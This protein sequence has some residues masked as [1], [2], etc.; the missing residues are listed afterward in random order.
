METNE[1]QKY[2]KTKKSKDDKLRKNLE[3]HKQNIKTEEDKH[4]FENVYNNYL[5]HL[6]TTQ[7]K[8]KKNI[9]IITT[10]I[11]KT[12]NDKKTIIIE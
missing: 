6:K 4:D 8:Y 11:F 5:Y 2:N 7:D 3:K 12:I 1:E 9:H 10:N